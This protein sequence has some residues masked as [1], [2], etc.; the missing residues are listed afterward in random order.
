MFARSLS[1]ALL[2]SAATTS[3]YSET[4]EKK[5]VDF[6][7]PPLIGKAI[8]NEIDQINIKEFDENNNQ[9]ETNISLSTT[10]AHKSN[11][12]RYAQIATILCCSLPLSIISGLMN[13]P[14]VCLLSTAIGVAATFTHDA[15]Q[16]T[17]LS[18]SVSVSSLEGNAS[19]KK[20]E[21]ILHSQK[22]YSWS[23]T[24]KNIGLIAV[25]HLCAGSITN[26]LTK[27]LDIKIKSRT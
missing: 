13:D 14:G 9:I 23:K 27:S 4:L 18:T 8:D 19:K 10:E 5:H 1:F 11:A 26:V 3:L 24:A 12:L 17:K 20:A 21:L 7:T 22:G 15:L 16:A 2:C 6:L 25:L